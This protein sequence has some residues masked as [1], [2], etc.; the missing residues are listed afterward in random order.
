[1]NFNAIILTQSKSRM[2]FQV[3]LTNSST[4]KGA[5]K[6]LLTITIYSINPCQQ[7][8]LPAKQTAFYFL[9]IQNWNFLW[10]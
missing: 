2:L 1:M 7:F 4:L 9:R 6:F 8:C 5:E 3:I 10:G